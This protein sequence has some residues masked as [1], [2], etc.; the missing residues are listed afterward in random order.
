METTARAGEEQVRV[1]TVELFFDLVF[2]FTITQLTALLAS[3]P[4]GTSLAQIVLML[5][6]IWWMYAAF[7][8]L[9]NAVTPNRTSLR[10]PLLAGMACFFVISLVIP[11]AFTGNGV[12]FAVAY[13]GVIAIH[14]AL[15]TQSASWSLASVWSF[16]RMNVIGG[17]L[18][19]A[20]AIVGGAWE[21]A[22]WVPA[23][24]LMAITPAL[25]TQDPGWIRVPHF[26]ERHGLVVIVALGE[27]VV[28]VGI[29][30]SGLQISIEMVA[31]AVLGLALT[32]ELWWTYFGGDENEAERALVG[33]KPDRRAFLAVNTA[34]YWAH[35]L[36]LLGIVCVAAT[37]E[38]AIAH[39]FDSLSFARALALGGGVAIFYLG[40]ILFRAALGLPFRAWR[41][42]GAALALATILLGTSTSALA[43]LGVLV[44][45]L[46]LCAFAEGE[47]AEPAVSET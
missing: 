1:T 39:P 3:K 23:I 26:V 7:A 40:D 5:V 12:V 13:L 4:T 29:G 2:V 19:L 42:F 8:W 37:L 45:A 35:V 43:Q 36:I 33:T 34:F 27:S 11:T 28:A 15:Y 18:I 24:V 31:V 25:I 38:R 44:A 21:Y 14:T 32:A 30:A 46:V 10:L 9:T 17:L 16:A 6:T 41:A 22:L 47:A 20:G